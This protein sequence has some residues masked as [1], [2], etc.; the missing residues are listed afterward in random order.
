MVTPAKKSPKKNGNIIAVI[1]VI[2]AVLVLAAVIAGAVMNRPSVK[3]PAALAKTI[4]AYGSIWEDIGLTDALSFLSEDQ[5][6]TSAVSV[7]YKGLGELLASQTAV[8]LSELEGLGIRIDQ[9]ISLEDRIYSGALAAVYQDVALVVANF[10][11][12]D[13]IAWVSVPELISGTYGMDTSILGKDLAKLGVEEDG[14]ESLGFNI[15][16]MAQL[17]MNMKPT[18]EILEAYAAAAKELSKAVE[19]E[20]KGSDKIKVNG[21]RISCDVYEMVIPQDALEDYLDALEDPTEQ[22]FDQIIDTY[23]EL[24][25]SA[26][27]PEEEIQYAME[28]SEA[29]DAKEILANLKDGLDEIGD[30][31]LEL[32]LNGGYVMAVVYELEIDGSEMTITLNMGG[33]EHYV[34]DFSLTVEGNGN[35]LKLSSSGNHT[36]K[37]GVYDDKTKLKRLQTARRPAPF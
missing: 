12:D 8:D 34:D 36:G 10:G 31:E 6:Y 28:G 25:R 5:A 32:Y 37:G 15:F 23:E 1:G 26:G 24:F 33:G 13:N 3:V 2:A 4:S 27:M 35:E 9:T 11:V 16:D 19:Y 20:D 30:I 18:E 21:S 22:Y 29:M 7:T 17:M 14:I